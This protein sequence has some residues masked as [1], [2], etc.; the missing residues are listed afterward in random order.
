VI[1]KKS[2]NQNLF[3]SK[4]S[5]IV[6]LTHAGLSF[7]N[8]DGGYLQNLNSKGDFNFYS[9]IKE[10]GQFEYK[11]TDGNVQFG[12]YGFIEPLFDKLKTTFYVADAAGTRNFKPFSDIVVFQEKG[13]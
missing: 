1:Q 12:C 9:Y 11:N 4:I 10:F 2:A 8:K 3:I 6:S 13:Y 7:S 5:L